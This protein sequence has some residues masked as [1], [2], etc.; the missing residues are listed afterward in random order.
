MFLIK[1]SLHL[2]IIWHATH[3]YRFITIFVTPISF[4]L[5]R[6]LW[7]HTFMSQPLLKPTGDYS[8]A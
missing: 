7:K 8:I 3:P 1:C 6:A 4:F 2:Q 5:L